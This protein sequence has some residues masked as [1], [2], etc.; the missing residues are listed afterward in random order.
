M[1]RAASIAPT[2]AIPAAD[3]MIELN[4]MTFYAYHGVFSQERT[5]GGRYSVSLRLHA[6]FDAATRSDDLADT[7]DYASAATIVKAEMERPSNLIEHVSR[8]I[9]ER[10]LDAFPQLDSVDVPICKHHPPVSGMEIAE[11]CFTASFSRND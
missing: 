9:A 5:V 8:R 11:A 2:A 10:L 1:K 6:D 4:D 3:D 7:L